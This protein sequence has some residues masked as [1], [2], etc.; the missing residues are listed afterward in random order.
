MKWT[1]YHTHSHFCDGDGSPEDYV[2]MA[3]KRNFLV[4]GFTSHAPAPF[5]T[6]WTMPRERF[7]E[8]LRVLKHL[9]IKYQDQIEILIGLEIDFIPDLQSIHDFDQYDLDYTLGS[10]HFLGEY[11][12]GY[13]WCVDNDP[14]ELQQGITESFGG[15][16]NA[17]IKEY[18]QRIKTMV[19]EAPPTI[20]GHLDLIK[21]NNISSPFFNERD[22][23]Y[24]EQVEQCL[25]V[26]RKST[27]VVEINT[28]GIARQ[29]YPEL[30]PSP[31]I[32]ERCAQLD[33]PMVLNS[34][35]HSPEGI[36]GYFT[37]ALKRLAEMGLPRL[38]YL[39]Q[40]VWKI[41]NY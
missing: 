25:Q 18:Y 34:D 3:I 41:V 16:I 28:G 38:N 31:W 40:G 5:P 37:T 8:Y 14:M 26:I 1:N 33:I 22:P 9:K 13:R 15:N 12:S 39:S 11:S 17:A 4:L 36:D 6:N 10:V 32:I 30:Y 35:C 19:I 21:K 27:C 23:F 24:Q 20:I 2:Q 7:N 29:R